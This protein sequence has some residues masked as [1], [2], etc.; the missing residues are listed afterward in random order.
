[1][2]VLESSGQPTSCAFSATQSYIVIG[3][4][5]EGSVV[6]WDLREPT[7]RH[8]DRY[9]H[10]IIIQTEVAIGIDLMKVCDADRD[11]IDLGIER[12]IRKPSYSS[13]FPSGD[14]SADNIAN[15]VVQHHTSSVIQV[16]TL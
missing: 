7:S 13:H 9:H 15:A 3:G 4:T 16:S 10:V 6:L 2:W 14:S 1:M 8:A 5:D 11:S 12:G